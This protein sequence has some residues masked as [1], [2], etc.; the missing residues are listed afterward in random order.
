M[1]QIFG[2]FTALAAAGL[3]V[4]MAQMI[5]EGLFPWPASMNFNNKKEVAAWMSNL[6]NRIFIIIAISHGVAAF[7]AGLI[8]SLVAGSHRVKTG[9]VAVCILIYII[10]MY[11][12]ENHFPLWFK[13][14]DI[15]TI[16]VMGGIG[17]T[18]GSARYV[19]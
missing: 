16:I 18:T 15:T 7:S 3:I 5:R 11:L 12:F 4:V 14:T 10:I 9:L 19:S 17:I 6:P 13:V 1:K 2:I 8:S